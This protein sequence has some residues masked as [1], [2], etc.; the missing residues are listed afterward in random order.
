[1][2]QSNR[3]QRNAYKGNPAR[4]LVR[5]NLISPE[6][7]VHELECLADT[8]NPCSLIIS[9]GMFRR[10]C[11][12]QSST[13]ESN[14]GTL[15]GG[16]LRIVVAELGFDQKVLGYANDMVVNVV[17]RSDPGFAGL[18]GLPLLR[19]MEYGGNS[20]AFWIRAEQRI[21]NS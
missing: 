12:R 20:E 8:G 2:R 21:D 6:H 16:W 14:F 17:K 10:L 19:L 11:W 13:M 4:A 15:D 3:E 7:E 9:V 18:V 1:M 5:L